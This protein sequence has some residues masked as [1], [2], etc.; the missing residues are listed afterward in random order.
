M[1]NSSHS[2][3][4]R[5]Y[6][7]ICP[8]DTIKVKQKLH[9]ITLHLNPMEK[10][11]SSKFC[12]LIRYDNFSFSSIFH[13]FSSR[14]FLPLQRSTERCADVWIPFCPESRE[15]K[16]CLVFDTHKKRFHIVSSLLIFCV[17]SLLLFFPCVPSSLK[18]SMATTLM[19]FCL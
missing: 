4:P 7:W 11:L 17:R 3:L 9:E 14:S 5:Q 10:S 16:L 13:R 8:I 6:K 1:R 15:N 19:W 18:C 2:L 12:V